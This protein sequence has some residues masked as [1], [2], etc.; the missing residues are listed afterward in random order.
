MK[1]LLI[2]NKKIY[3]KWASKTY[4]YKMD[5]IDK[6]YRFTHICIEDLKNCESYDD[7]LNHD[8]ILF[9]WNAN[10]NSKFYTTKHHYYKKEYKKE[11]LENE[12][13]IKNL[14][15]PLMVHSNKYQM[16]QDLHKYDC[17]NGMIGLRNYLKKHNFKGIVTPYTACTEISKFKDFEI[18]QIPHH[19][20]NNIFKDYNLEKDTDIFIYGNRQK[21]NYPFRHRLGILLDKI[22]KKH[23]LNVVIWSGIGRHY[24]NFDNVKDQSN[25][26]LSKMINR[27]WLTVCTPNRFNFLLGKY[28]ETSM[29]K[30]TILGNMPKD[31]KEIWKDNFVELT[32]NMSDEKIEEIVINALQDKERLKKNNS[33]GIEL[34]KN[35][36]LSDFSNH[37]FNLFI[38]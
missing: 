26:N 34:M 30:S 17:E 21:S 10:Y 4:E 18:L 23:N 12:N 16:V 37:L 14:I 3:R 36:V 6:D 15:M 25:E 9:G 31:G 19:I 13:T 32:N 2:N 24:F 29:S 35:Y 20:D 38:K 28:F 7:Y 8:V 1:I 11:G 27:S 5:V 33:Y 22:G